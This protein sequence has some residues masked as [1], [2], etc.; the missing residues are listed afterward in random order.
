M[1]KLPRRREDTQPYRVGWTLQLGRARGPHRAGFDRGTTFS[2][3]ERVPDEGSRLEPLNCSSLRQEALIPDSLSLL[4]SAAT[5]G[6]L[7]PGRSSGLRF[8]RASHFAD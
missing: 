5:R 6:S 1:F 8:G 3:V 7:R 4:T 2:E